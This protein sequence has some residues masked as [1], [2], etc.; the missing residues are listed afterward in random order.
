MSFEFNAAL[1]KPATG[2]TALPKGAY[3][4]VLTKSEWVATKDSA[5]TANPILQIKAEF[6]V[7]DSHPDKGRKFF[8]Y[9]GLNSDNEVAKEI[10]K[11][12]I[13]ALCHSTGIMYPKGECLE[14][15]YGVPVLVTVKVTADGFNDLVKIEKLAG[16]ASAVGGLPPAQLPAT[17]TVSSLPSFGSPPAST[18]PTPPV[19]SA[20]TKTMT[21]AANG[22]TYEQLIQ[23]GWTEQ[24]MIDAGLMV[25]E[26][27]A[28]EPQP[29]VANTIPAAPAA[30]PL[31]TPLSAT[32]GW[33]QPPPA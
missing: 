4:M 21:A 23:A 7:H 27:A 16:A 10:A 33:M 11:G 17:N 25:L 2:M 3:P 24:Q 18:P 29:P 14:M 26:T 8:V 6:T 5:Q 13:S 20:P 15:L 12:E 22:A 9:W 1:V 28:P 30:N 19:A 31:D 32:P